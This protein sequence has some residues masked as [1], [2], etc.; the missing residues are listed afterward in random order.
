VLAVALALAA[1]LSWGLA[2]FLAGLKSRV[3]PVLTVIALSQVA[4]L[5]VIVAIVL[6]RGDGPPSG[7][8]VVFAVLSSAAGLTGLAAFYRGLA[9]G[10]MAVVA[11]ISALGAGIP[12][13]FGLAQGERPSALQATGIALAIVGVV[14]ASRE[15]HPEGDGTRRAAGVGLALVAAVGFGSFFVALD[16]ASKD[17]VLWALLVNRIAGVSLM[18]AACA[19]LRPTLTPSARDTGA[20][21]AIGVFDMG[22]NGLFALA[23]NEGL[24]S[25]VAVLASLYPVVVIGLAH[26]VLRERIQPWQWAGVC[27]ALAGVALIAAG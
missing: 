10:A 5:A 6:A 14:L 9:V 13:V 19:V 23:T 1:S 15:K 21:L 11:P 4:G 25:V 16:E 22:A 2:D 8:F 18:A 7:E 27:F 24:V 3:L 26:A 12:V 17:D 20:L